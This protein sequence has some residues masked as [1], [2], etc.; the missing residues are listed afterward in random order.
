[1]WGY[2]FETLAHRLRAA[3]FERIE[4]AE[5][6]IS[7]DPEL[8]QDREEHAPYSLYV[9][10]VRQAVRRVLMVSPHFPPDTNAA[11]HRVRLLAPHLPAR[12]WE[13]T[14]VAVDPRDYEG[15]L[16]PALADR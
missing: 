7:R 14:V 2:D 10:A 6:K 12:G 13:P 4:R 15:R 8:G 3:G 1:R 11:T 16:D 5:Y 9:E